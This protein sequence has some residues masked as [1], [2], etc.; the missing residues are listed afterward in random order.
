[1]VGRRSLRAAT[2]VATVVNEVGAAHG[3]ASGTAA[4]AAAGIG[5]FLAAGAAAAG[6]GIAAV[7][8]S[9]TAALIEMTRRIEPP[10]CW[11]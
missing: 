7:A 9:A 11:G 6:F 3:P 8:T 10:W 4:T 1:L 5:A 2:F